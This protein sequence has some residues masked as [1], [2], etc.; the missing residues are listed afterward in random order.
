MNGWE[1]LDRQEL[2][3]F[4]ADTTAVDRTM[5]ASTRAVLEGCFGSGLHD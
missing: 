5:H 2:C 4:R 1:L 3:V